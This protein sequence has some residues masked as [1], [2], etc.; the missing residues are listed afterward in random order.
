M[1]CI[2]I[3]SNLGAYVLGGLEPEEAAEV[4]RHL[5]F[6][7]RCRNELE[8]LQKINQPLEAAPPLADPPDNLK[9]EI[10]SRVREEK[11]LSSIKKEQ[12]PLE[13]STPYLPRH[14][15][16]GSGLH[17]WAR[18]PHWI[19]GA[20]FSDYRTADSHSCAGQ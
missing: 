2:E 20:T 18:N 16:R 15:C 10:L 6:C 1:R 11:N 5:T 17:S 12:T 8:G 7:S 13:R 3:H 19:A 9:D 14:S 4:R